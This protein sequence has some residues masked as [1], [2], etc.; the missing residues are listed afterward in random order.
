MCLTFD[1]KVIP[2]KHPP[3]PKRDFRNMMNK[4][5]YI[6]GVTANNAD[7]IYYYLPKVRGQEK[8]ARDTPPPPPLSEILEYDE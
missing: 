8:S 7:T 4:S 6:G 2:V 1:N 3:P 5:K